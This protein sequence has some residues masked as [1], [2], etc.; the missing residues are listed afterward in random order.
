MLTLNHRLSLGAKVAR[1]AAFL[2]LALG[3]TL[4][5]S[6][7]ARAQWTTSGNNTTTTNNVGIG[8][9]APSQM[10]HIHSTGFWAGTRVTTASTGTTINDGV[11]FG[12]DDNYGAYIWNR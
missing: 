7:E 11:H 2:L 3:A 4:S 6:R 8:T 5:Q 10:F 9:T 12:Y 1:S